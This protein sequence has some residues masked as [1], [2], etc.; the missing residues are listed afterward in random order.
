V[1]CAPRATPPDTYDRW[2]LVLRANAVMSCTFVLS[3]N[4]PKPEAG[5]SI[6]GPSL[7]IGPDGS[8]LAETTEP[9]AVVDLDRTTL[10]RC[11]VD[12]PGYLRRFPSLYADGWRDIAGRRP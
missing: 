1:V 2:R 8:V 10:R 9:V 7:G 6:G 3:V 11:R 12:Y 5:A 4:R